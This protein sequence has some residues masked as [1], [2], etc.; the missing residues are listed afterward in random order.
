MAC[1]KGTIELASG[2]CIKPFSPQMDPN[3][4]DPELFIPELGVKVTINIRWD[5]VARTIRV[6]NATVKKYTVKK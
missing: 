2:L 4:F 1:T 6:E 3:G 5:L